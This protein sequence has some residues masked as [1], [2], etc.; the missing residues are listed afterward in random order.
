MRDV[1]VVIPAFN[2]AQFLGDAIESVIASHDVDAQIIVVD[3]GS[4]DSSAAVAR[5]FPQVEL[6][7]Q[8]NHGAH[9]AINAGVRASSREIIAILNDDDVYEPDYLREVATALDGG[10][11][12]VTLT[13]PRVFGA[14]ELRRRMDAHTKACDNLIV[15]HGFAWALLRH[16]WFVGTSGVAFTRAAFDG[17]QGFRTLEIL[18]DHDFALR[19]MVDLRV[20]VLPGPHGRWSYRCHATNTISTFT[21][22]QLAAEREIALRPM[23]ERY[24]SHLLPRTVDV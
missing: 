3:D 21:E 1:S 12:D 11:A 19:A 10:E 15:R 6:L 2:H 18:H 22:E 8:R 13:R 9:G 5:S 24:A 4:T 23:Q 14:G 17:L 20:R 16:N 7:S